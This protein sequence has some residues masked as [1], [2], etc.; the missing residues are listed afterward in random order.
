[1]YK[2]NGIINYDAGIVVEKDHPYLKKGYVAV[3]SDHR[4]TLFFK[5]D[6]AA[7]KHYELNPYHLIQQI[8][9]TI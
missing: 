4:R 9:Y 2:R 5:T 3:C 7:F 1:M 6:E 8:S